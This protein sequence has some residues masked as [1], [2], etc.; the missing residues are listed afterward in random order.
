MIELGLSDWRPLARPPKVR[1][2][3]GYRVEIHWS[4][5]SG[6]HP[7]FHETYR[8]HVTDLAE[9][10]HRVREC[11]IPGIARGH[12]FD[13]GRRGYPLNPRISG[14]EVTAIDETQYLPATRYEDAMKVAIEKRAAE[15]RE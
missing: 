12:A 1:V 14:I 4:W 5:G 11:V 13:C 6:G 2:P 10:D 15:C 8:F 9:V 7:P 3:R